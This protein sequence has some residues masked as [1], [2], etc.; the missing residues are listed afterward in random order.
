MALILIYSLSFL[1]SFPTFVFVLPMLH[2]WW[3]LGL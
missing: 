3:E 1:V 2:T